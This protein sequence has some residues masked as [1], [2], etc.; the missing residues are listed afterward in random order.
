MSWNSIIG[1]NKLKEQ[2]QNIITNNKIANAY[3]IYGNQ[4][5]GQD[6]IALEFIKS[7][8]CKTSPSNSCGK[9]K[10]CEMISNFSHPNLNL[11]FSMPAL[12]SV[13]SKENGN[14]S[15]QTYSQSEKVKKEVHA[16]LKIKSANPY[17]TLQLEDANTILIEQV[18][19]MQKNFISLSTYAEGIKFV[20]ILNAD[21]MND[22]SSN[23]LLKILEEPSKNSTFILTT[24]RIENLLPTI[25]SRCQLLK[26]L[27]LANDAIKDALVEKYN[28]SEENALLLAKISNGS[29][30]N[31]VD[32]HSSNLDEL[33]NKALKSFEVIINSNTREVI[34]HVQ[35]IL[36]EVDKNRNL[37]K[38]RLLL[39]YYLIR[40]LLM[41][42]EETPS[43]LIN[44]DF[45]DEL[46][47]FLI[48][49]DSD[50]CQSGM[51]LCESTIEL[52]E[53]Y[54]YL[55]LVLNSFAI[56]LKRLFN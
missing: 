45:K 6:A 33:R 22:V 32:L 51:N 18:R 5:V 44:R 49:S 12:K 28:L 35:N 52:L 3:C 36:S 43:L 11:L 55:P 34:K 8:L 14:N 17:H 48:K 41:L 20:L 30:T 13:K 50:S 10:N 24:S 47:K 29:F 31:A 9:C 21:E 19:D 39:I 37:L 26:C 15:E 56:K 53:S 4:G 38:T 1:Q 42:V 2:L 7:L 25:I 16:Q 23:A 54:V 40:D 46:E 27:P